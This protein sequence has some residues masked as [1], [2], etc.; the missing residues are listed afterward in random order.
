MSNMPKLEK[1]YDEIVVSEQFDFI[2]AD[3]K[4]EE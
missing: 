4:A 2:V 3:F 1:K